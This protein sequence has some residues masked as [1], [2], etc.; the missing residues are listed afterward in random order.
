[1]TE[2]LLKMIDYAFT[3]LDLHRIEANIMPRNIPSLNLVRKL[4]FK[5]EGL[6]KS[7]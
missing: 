4:G 6:A 5:E 2:A 7:I 3:T 1:M